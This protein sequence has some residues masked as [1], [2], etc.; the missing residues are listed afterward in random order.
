[1]SGPRILTGDVDLMAIH[2]DVDVWLDQED[3]SCEGTCGCADG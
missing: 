3:C 1:M 2:D